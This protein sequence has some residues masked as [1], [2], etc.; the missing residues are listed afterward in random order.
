MSHIKD[1]ESEIATFISSD[2]VRVNATV[3]DGLRIDIK[4]DWDGPPEIIGAIVGDII[5]N[6]RASLD[7]A[8]CDLVRL[9][10][11]NDNKVYFPFCDRPEE[12][13]EMIRRR[14]FKR[15]G[16]R[17]V[18][19]LHELRPY[20]NGNVALR[21]IH[22]LDVQD[23][24]HSLIPG[25]MMHASPIFRMR[26]NAGQPNISIFGDLTPHPKSK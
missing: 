14:N 20:R 26:D 17:A 10:G 12:L 3:T 4:M 23:K 9:R 15:A 24:H 22:D 19:L 18:A 5:H 16:P 7:L 11:G 13:D 6:L 2:P 25:A 8:A 1:L 21:A